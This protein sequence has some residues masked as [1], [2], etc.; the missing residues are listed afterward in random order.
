MNFG[1]FAAVALIALTGCAT[2]KEA[3]RVEEPRAV[4]VQTAIAESSMRPEERE[5]TGTV[6]AKTTA[7]VSSRIAGHIKELRV[8][9]GDALSSGQT[10][11]VI[12]TREVETAIREAEA[13][14]TEAQAGLPESEAALRG[15]QAQLDLARTTLDRMT[16]LKDSK[17]ITDQEFDETRARFRQ[18]Q[19]QVDIAQ[20]RGRQ[21][22]E[23][24]QQASAA[25]ERV[26][27][28]RNYATVTAPF[29]GI[30]TE[31]RAEAGVFA[32]PGQPIVVIERAGEWRLDAAVDESLLKHL[33][34]GT[35][36]SVTLDALDEP[37][38][39]R[40]NE[41]LPS[42]DARTRTATVRVALPGW[43]GIRSGLSGRMRIAGGERKAIT[44]PSSAVLTNGQ[45]Q[46]V[47]VLSDG[48]LRAQLVT[49][50]ETRDGKTEIVSGMEGGERIASPA[51]AALTDGARVEV[52]Q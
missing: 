22:R 12:D 34:V 2:K 45:L 24:I 43:A 35:A 37:M 38:A 36:V 23:R 30:V 52:V 13:G 19:S 9:E 3:P 42:V 15:A 27:L 44:V 7:A 18:A 21:I 46:R 48:R 33:R 49:A 11:A 8:R 47:F 39:L 31:K 10:I 28:Q 50:G 6:T 26:R 40:L 25:V 51:S 29:A 20:A 16:K 14:R 41:I 32:G 1:K 4:R 17:S 5:F